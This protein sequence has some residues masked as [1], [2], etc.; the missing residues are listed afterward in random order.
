MTARRD[1]SE[2]L[3]RVPTTP[4][5]MS[6]AEVLAW[7]S[8]ARVCIDRAT[9]TRGDLAALEAASRA[10]AAVTRLHVELRG[11]PLTVEGSAGQD[12]A[13]PLLV[14]AR[15]WHAVLRGWLCEL[16]LTPA[17]RSRTE[18]LRVSINASPLAEFL[19]EAQK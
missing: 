1:P 19:K 13:N 18:A 8:L 12:R 14:E 16:G 5:E 4:P 11:A 10:L 3:T 17:A 15:G 9:L 6:E 7:R 2:P